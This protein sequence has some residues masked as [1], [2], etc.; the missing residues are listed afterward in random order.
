MIHCIVN[1]ESEIDHFGEI[2]IELGLPRWL[3]NSKYNN[4]VHAKGLSLM[5]HGLAKDHD[6]AMRDVLPPSHVRSYSM[7]QR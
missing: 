5:D 3:T 2:V 7:S 6:L 4:I 1:E